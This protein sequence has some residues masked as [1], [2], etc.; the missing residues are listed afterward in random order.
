MNRPTLSI[1]IPLL[2]EQ[3]VLPELDRRL[4]GLLASLDVTW[5][6]IFVNDGSTDRTGEMLAE[7][8][9][10]EPRFKVLSFSRNFGHQIAVTAGMDYAVGEAVVVIDADLQD[11]PELIRQMLDKWREGFDIVYAVRSKREGESYFKRVTAAA[12]YRFMQTMVGVKFPADAGDFRLTSRRAVLALRGLRETHRFVRGFVVW[13]GFKQAAVTFVRAGRF[14]GETKYPL[15]KMLR[16][17]MDGITS[18]S[19]VPL[20]ISSYLGVLSGMA[21][22]GIAAWALWVR[23]FTRGVVPGWTSLLIAFSV[24]ASAQFLMIGILGEYVGR[25]YEEVKRR[26]LYVIAESKNV[27]SK[28]S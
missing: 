15:R 12:F 8:A 21:S 28:D 24:V 7:L 1:I 17:A 25:I 23:F 27:E 9:A 20:R 4:R 26:P 19:T 14:A 13:V 16:F 5:E 10:N 2:N 18:F 22:L 3:E 11:P 6:T